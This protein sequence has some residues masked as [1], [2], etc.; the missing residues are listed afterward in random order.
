MRNSTS[1]RIQNDS[2]NAVKG[3]MKAQSWILKTK[4][5]RM[6]RK[7]NLAIDKLNS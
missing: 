1:N 7:I 2:K 5:K 6:I 3:F 4:D